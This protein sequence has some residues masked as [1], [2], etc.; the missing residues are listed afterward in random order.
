MRAKITSLV[1]T[2]LAICALPVA[3]TGLAAD[4]KKKITYADDVSAIFRNRCG[5]CHNGDKQKGGL[6]LDSYSTALRGGGSGAVIEPGDPENSTILHLINQTEEPKMPPNSPKI[7]DAEIALIRQWI[8]GGALE[9]SGSV[10]TVKAKPK[11]EFKV[12]PSMLGKP[13]G[14]A[15][16]P[17]ELATEPFVPDAKSGAVVALAASPWAPLVAVGGHKQVLLYRTTDNHLAGVLPFPEGTIHTLRF[18]RNGDL[19]LAGGGRGGKMGLAV[20]WDVKNGKRVFEIGKEYD[21]VLAADIS[22]DHSQVALGGP[23]KVVRVYNTAD[24]SL[25][26]EMKKHTDWIT[27]AEFSPDGALLATGDRSNGLIAWEAGTGRE[28]HDLR[29]H[30][31]MI[32]DVSW[33]LDSN[34][35]ASASEDGSVRLWEMENGGNIKTI[36]AHSG[37][38]SSV[39]FTKSGGLITSGR[40][41][42]VRLW[43]ANGAKKRDFEAF[44]DIALGAVVSSDES[45]ALGVDWTGELRVWDVKDGRRVANLAVNPAPIVNRIDQNKKALAAAQTE[46][47]AVSKK[48][49]PAQAAVDAAKAPLAKA[50]EAVAVAEKI[51]AQQAAQLARSEAELKAKIAAVQDAALTSQTADQLAK[52]AQ[53]SQAT[54]EKAVGESAVAVKA[55]SDALAAETTKLDQAL[56]AK[57]AHDPALAAATAAVK[58]GATADATAKAVSDLTAQVKKAQD[59]ITALAAAGSARVEAQNR[60]VRA[61][62]ARAAAPQ[63]LQAAQTRAKA[64]ALGAQAARSALDG[65]TAAKTAGEKAVADARAAAQ[66][67]TATLTA[68]KKSLDSLNAAHAAAAKALADTNAAIQAAQARAVSLKA[69]IEMLAVEKKRSDAATGG[70]ATTARPSP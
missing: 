68:A 10:A 8:E 20:A 4:A 34:V 46:A 41:R 57:A 27:A 61:T 55:A 63:A 69:E 13:A 48:L 38:A 58:A 50:G 18:S 25:M 62:A 26:F 1:L 39:R 29:G 17:V 3:T 67:S 33:R 7:P 21:A 64:L 2:S 47:E 60:L 23:G 42:F 65:A 54:A 24:G 52:Q 40:D 59:L 31:Q 30:T 37:G 45:R 5:S 44:G 11:F 9:T 70:L 14:P 51:N 22:P 36:S 15:A 32:T 53:E 35:F 43:D 12:D 16:M 6:N 56:A 66:A 28:F 19:L 49:A